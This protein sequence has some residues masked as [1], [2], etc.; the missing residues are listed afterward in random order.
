MR[1]LREMALA[2][3]YSAT[4]ASLHETPQLLLR[5]EQAELRNMTPLHENTCRATAYRTFLF[6]RFDHNPGTQD[7]IM[8][9]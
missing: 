5:M 7:R 2:R 8:D 9:L 4:C 6:S 1:V 3:L